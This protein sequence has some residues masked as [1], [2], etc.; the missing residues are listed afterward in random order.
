MCDHVE[1]C[2]KTGD[3]GFVYT[4]SLIGY[5]IR[6]VTRSSWNHAFL[7]LVPEN[8]EPAKII[9]AHLTGVRVLPITH[10]TKNEKYDV[11]IKR[12]RDELTETDKNKLFTDAI[13]R[14]GKKYDYSGILGL[15]L[16]FVTG[17]RSFF[18]IFDT[19]KADYC[20]EFICEI[21]AETGRYFDNRATTDMSP[22][23]LEKSNRL[24]KIDTI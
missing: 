10:Y 12:H 20:S 15:F 3:I 11:L 24:V 13:R 4:R 17:I 9:E 7:V 22:G 14:V 23:E 8:N 21:Y 16:Y 1:C 19:S 18:R 5:C 6:I 2:P